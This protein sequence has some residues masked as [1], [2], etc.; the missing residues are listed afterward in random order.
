[1]AKEDT[2]SFLVL[3]LSLSCIRM[4]STAHAG[5]SMQYFY[6]IPSKFIMIGCILLDCV[7]VNVTRSQKFN[8]LDPDVL[9]AGEGN[10]V[11]VSCKITCQS[12]PAKCQ[13]FSPIL[14]LT[15]PENGVF[16]SPI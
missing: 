11:E 8:D 15:T 10:P 14:R 9:T 16:H 4:T 6:N 1:M 5:K 2:S 12:Q 7:D 3:M 13:L